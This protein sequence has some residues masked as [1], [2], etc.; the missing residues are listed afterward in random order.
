NVNKVEIFYENYT[1]RFFA[2]TF[3]VQAFR[4]GLGAEHKYVKI[5]TETILEENSENQLPFTILEETNL[6]S[7]LGYLELDTY[8]KKYFPSKGLYFRGDFHGYLF[9]SE[10]TS[11]FSEFAIAKGAFGYAFGVSHNISARIS[12]E[13]GFRIGEGG[14]KPLNFFLGGYGNHK[15]NN[16]VP[17]Y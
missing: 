11:D 14:S 7:A 1:N 16:I 3:F 8:D 10:S 15:I 12:S 2:E 9:A 4:L 13:T 5:K 6:F 17:F